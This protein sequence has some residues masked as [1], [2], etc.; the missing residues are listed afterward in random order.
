MVQYLNILAANTNSNLPADS[1]DQLLHCHIAV[2][3][4]SGLDHPNAQVRVP[5]VQ[6]DLAGI[7]QIC[8]EFQTQLGRTDFVAVYGTQN[9]DTGL[10]PHCFVKTVSPR[11]IYT[12]PF[13]AFVATAT[14]FTW[15]TV[16][17]DAGVPSAF[18]FFRPREKMLGRYKLF[19]KLEIEF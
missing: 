1:Q 5:F 17:G 19:Y 9:A 3:L 18:T 14:V 4:N 11:F 2:H 6:I 13:F 15:T 12:W 16:G 8:Q 7:T 10:L